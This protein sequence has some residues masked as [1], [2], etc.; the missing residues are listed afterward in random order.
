MEPTLVEADR[1][2][3]VYGVRARLGDVVAVRL[4]DSPDGPRPVA[5]KRLTRREPDGRLWVE[6]D[7]TGVGT[8]SWRVGALP[9]E[10]LLAVAP[11]RLP[12]HGRGLTWLHR[13]R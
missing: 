9:P 10:A 11:L 7:A 13:R 1:V 12:R 2:L 3:L 6:S 8:D 4:P 5:I